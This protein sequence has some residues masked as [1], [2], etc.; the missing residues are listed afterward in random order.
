[1]YIFMNPTQNCKKRKK[2][3]KKKR[4]LRYDMGIIPAYSLKKIIYCKINE[5]ERRVSSNAEETRSFIEEGK[6]YISCVTFDQP[7]FV[8][9]KVVLVVCLQWIF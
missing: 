6:K 7:G 8:A 5:E 1:M 4:H 3:K 9:S 2:K